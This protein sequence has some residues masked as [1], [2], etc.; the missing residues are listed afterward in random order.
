MLQDLHHIYERQGKTAEGETLM[1]EHKT[2]ILLIRKYE[3]D[4]NALKL[5]L[6]M[7]DTLKGRGTV[8]YD[9]S[10]DEVAHMDKKIKMYLSGDPDVDAKTLCSDATTIRHHKLMF[11][12]FKEQYEKR[13]QELLERGGRA[14]GPDDGD[15]G[16]GGFPAAE[17]LAADEPGGVGVEEAGGDA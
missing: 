11:E 3:Q 2:R 4:I 7:H 15:G 16:D 13:S 14:G 10:P 6:K 9:P 1:K 5:E 17:D 12:M 8:D